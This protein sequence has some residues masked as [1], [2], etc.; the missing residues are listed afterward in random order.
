MRRV[1][2]AVLLAALPR[3]AQAQEQKF[4]EL[5]DFKL[6]SGEVIR[7][8]RIG[9]RTFG[10]L[11]AR[12]S[13]AVLVLT[14]FTG[15]SGMLAGTFGA[16][17]WVSEDHYGIAVD[18]LGDGVSSSPS[19][20]AVQ[21][22]MKFPRFTIRDMVESQRQLLRVLGID[23]LRAVLGVSMGGMQA[24]QWAFSHPG[25]MDKV[26]AVQ[27]SP[28]LAA[29]DLMLWQAQNDAIML[30]PA[31]NNGDYQRPPGGKLV[32][33][34]S[35]LADIAPARFNRDHSRERAAAA[36]AEAARDVERFDANDRIRQIQAMMTHDVSAPFGGSLER[37]AAA[38]K[39]K[40][41]VVVTSSDHIVT[42][43]PA[44]ELARAARAQVLELRN[45]CGHNG[46]GCEP[47][48][49]EQAVREFLAR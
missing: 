23:H 38:I 8:C 27:G 28:R 6:E 34:I 24:F 35:A 39:A 49:V 16:G 26:I 22:R 11:D 37:A 17:G 40:M 43:S 42:P 13:N 7:R 29:Y 36:V 32:A 46:G 18:A 31:W 41:L 21:P 15:N 3:A 10:R 2:L 48:R 20:S 12:R 45:D 1:V 44:L 47:R 30:D 4:A 19:N 33:A 5:G 14:W 9:Y 25:F